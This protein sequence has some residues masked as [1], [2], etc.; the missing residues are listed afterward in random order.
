M[1]TSQPVLK[2]SF[3]THLELAFRATS[4][5]PAVVAVDPAASQDRALWDPGSWRSMGIF[6]P[7]FPDGMV[8]P[9]KLEE[10]EHLGAGGFGSVTKCRVIG[11]DKYVAVKRIKKCLPEEQALASLVLEVHV[12]LLMDSCSAVPDVHGVFETKEAFYIVMDCGQQSFAELPP[13]DRYLA[14]VYSAQLAGVVWAMHAMGIIH[15][16]LKPANLI[17][18][19][20]YRL[21]V[22]DFGLVDVFDG[23][24]GPDPQQ[25][26]VWHALRAAGTDSFPMLWPGDDNPHFT[27]ARGGTR[28]YRCPQA[29]MGMPCSY[30]ADLWALGIIMHKWYTNKNP[31]FEENV[32]HYDREDD[33]STIEIDFFTK[34]FSCEHPVRF[35]SW[36]EISSHPIWVLEIET[37]CESA[38]EDDDSA[39]SE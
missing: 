8:D 14:Q 26:P 39:S 23:D 5:P 21:Q 27:R 17:L 15:F 18:D 3:L 4:T 38:S 19:D 36:E 24:E 34:I 20:N 33:L 29:Q 12:L 32:W 2:Q 31:T 6:E 9:F 10:V 25:W 7:A 37:E 1:P 30:A 28:G 22:V 11:F 16:D 13:F 35:E